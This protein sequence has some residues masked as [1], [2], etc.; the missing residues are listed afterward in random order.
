VQ[1]AL[2]QW[3]GLAGEGGTIIVGNVTAATPPADLIPAQPGA[4]V[5][6]LYLP[7][8][9]PIQ[10]GR[11]GR[12]DFPSGYYA[13]TGSA[14]GPGG[15]A[16]RLGR[17]LRARPSG[18]DSL[19]NAKRLHWHI[20]YLLLRASVVQVWFAISGRRREHSWARR[21]AGMP[22]AAVI[23]PRFGASDCHCPAHLLHLA[24]LPGPE[25]LGHQAHE[26]LTVLDLE[27]I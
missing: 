27:N 21:L 25:A 1:T 13:Y 2:L 16:A 15:L 10:I 12:F 24:V 17:H 19:N 5:L 6:L 4:Y 14:L 8:S 20:D 22:G 3:W 26:R 11:L 18:P 23:A 9:G 7:V